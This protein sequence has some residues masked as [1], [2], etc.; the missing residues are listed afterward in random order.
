MIRGTWHKLY[1]R[2]LVPSCRPAPSNHLQKKYGRG[3]KTFKNSHRQLKD[4]LGTNGHP[5]PHPLGIGGVGFHIPKIEK[6]SML[7]YPTNA[8]KLS[9]T[10]PLSKRAYIRNHAPL[11]SLQFFLGMWMG[12]ELLVIAQSVRIENEH[13]HR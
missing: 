12:G 4:H 3:H 10:H 9:T 5:T 1:V 11:R 8:C 7:I 6:N 2:L 13:I